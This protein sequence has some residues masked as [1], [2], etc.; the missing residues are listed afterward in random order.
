MG[1]KFMTFN[2][3]KRLYKNIIY[4]QKPPIGCQ[5]SKKYSSG[6]SDTFCQYIPIA[7]AQQISRTPPQS[8]DLE[9]ENIFWEE[10]NY[11]SPETFKLTLTQGRVYGD[12]I[13]IT[14]DNYVLR[15]VSTVFTKRTDYHWICHSGKLPPPMYID[16]TIAVLSSAGA[17]N[18]YH[19]MFDVLPRF[20]MINLEEIDFLYI[21]INKKFQK[22]YLDFLNIPQHKILPASKSTHIQ[23]KTLLI[24][25][26]PGTTGRMTEDSCIYLKEL[27]KEFCTGAMPKKRLY[28]S[29][30]DAK[31]RKVIN[32]SEIIPILQNYNFEVAHLTGL[33]VKD[34]ISLF[35]SAEA[36]I[37]PH[38]A[39]LSNIVFCSPSTKIIEFFTPDYLNACFWSLSE[40]CNLNYSYLVGDK[41][42][43]FLRRSKN[44]Y[45]CPKK[46]TS[47]MSNLFD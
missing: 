40:I 34:Q 44:M 29:R 16:Q 2:T 31:S 39:G 33:S 9:I 14:P 25:S 46:L 11:I 38:G 5:N 1:S 13:I 23:A 7:Q 6:K 10:A 18:Y 43:Q 28:I 20:M 24:P 36:I 27:C 30:K 35:S 22:D 4:S 32:E 15:D 21:N 17:D 41:E 37:G 12:G 47:L 26:L 45:I 8:A 19:W 42:H 3:L